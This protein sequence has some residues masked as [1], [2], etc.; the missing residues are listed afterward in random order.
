MTE[1]NLIKIG[2]KNIDRNSFMFFRESKQMQIRSMKL[3]GDN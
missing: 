3:Y 1:A 2:S